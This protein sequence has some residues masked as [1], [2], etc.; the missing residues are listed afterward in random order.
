MF[1]C[2]V[3]RIDSV[4][5]PQTEQREVDLPGESTGG[6]EGMRRSLAGGGGDKDASVVV[7]AKRYFD[8][9][10]PLTIASK[11]SE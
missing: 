9:E 2:G 3:L 11:P 5:L 8:V 6:R 1:V 4:G 10:A 7:S